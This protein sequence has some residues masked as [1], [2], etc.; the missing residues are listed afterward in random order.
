MGD[1]T[2]GNYKK[3]IPTGGLLAPSLRQGKVDV[4]KINPKRM[5]K[6]IG[7]FKNVLGR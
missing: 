6:G 1:F 3:T 2:L 4:H 7:N 5:P